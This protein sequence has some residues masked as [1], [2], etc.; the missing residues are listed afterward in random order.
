[1]PTQAPKTTDARTPVWAKKAPSHSR[2]QQLMDG[3]IKAYCDDPNATLAEVAF[4]LEC[5]TETVR[6][7]YALAEARG[8]LPPFRPQPTRNRHA[9][10]AVQ[11]PRD[12]SDPASPPSRVAAAERRLG[13]GVAGPQAHGE[14]AK[15]P[16]ISR[17]P[18]GAP[19]A[20]PHSAALRTLPKPPRTPPKPAPAPVRPPKPPTPTPAREPV[21]AAAI[22]VADDVA[23][24]IPP[25]RI[26]D[27]KAERLRPEPVPW[28]R[29]GGRR[30]P[31]RAL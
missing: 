25:E 5:K 27:R 31:V 28:P 6:A 9:S 15:R 13:E 18:V 8:M 3:V 24:F 23:P 11:A 16:T 14:K 17:S 22:A 4:F 19:E 7:Y 26:M 10:K 30:N 12:G 1:M 29:Y 20:M 2:K 21:P